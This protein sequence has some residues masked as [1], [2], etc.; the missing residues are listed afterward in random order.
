MA[1]YITCTEFRTPTGYITSGAG[2]ADSS[3][4][5]SFAAD[6]THPYRPWKSAGNISINS[7][8]YGVD[9]GSAVEL[10]GVGIDNV[11][12]GAVTLEAASDSAFTSNVISLGLLVGEN[13]VERG[14]WSTTN[15]SLGRLKVFVDLAGTDFDGQTRRYW[16]IVSAVGTTI[17]G[18]SAPMVVGSVAWCKDLQRWVSGTSSYGEQP[19]EATRLNDDY[20]GGGAEPVILGNPYAAITLAGAPAA[21][22]MRPLMMRV[23]RQG[24]GRPFLFYRNAGDTADFYICTRAT[25]ISV[26]TTAPTLIEFDQF[27]LR[28]AV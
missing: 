19:I 1:G 11:N 8:F 20:A 24:L 7:T 13:T 23:L 3:F 22:E 2:A 26:R 18:A 25:D 27:V 16:R 15:G 6:I 12:V 10:K 28:S 5:H 21:L 9:M 4:P 14:P 17:E